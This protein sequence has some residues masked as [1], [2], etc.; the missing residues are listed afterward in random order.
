MRER[1]QGI[2]EGA[3]RAPRLASSSAAS[4]A[5]RNEC[6]AIQCRLIKLGGEK[7]VPARSAMRTERKSDRSRR[8]EKGQ[9]Y[10]CCRDQQSACR[11]V[12]ASA[13]K[14][15][16]ARPAEKERVASVPQ[17]EQLAS[18]PEPYLPKKKEQ[19]CQSKAPN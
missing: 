1:L 19:S 9:T 6:P 2:A 3:S 16:H 18:T 12:Q 11:M 8:E 15:E 14:L 13:E 5:G 7:T 17:R 10:W 4:F